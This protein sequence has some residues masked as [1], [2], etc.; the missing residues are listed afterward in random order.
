MAMFNPYL[1]AIRKQFL[2]K[3]E[4]AQKQRNPGGKRCS[5]RGCQYFESSASSPCGLRCKLQVLERED[6]VQRDRGKWNKQDTQKSPRTSTSDK[7]LPGAG[8]NSARGTRHSTKSTRVTSST[9]RR[10]GS[11]EPPAGDTPNDIDRHGI[12][13][14]LGTAAERQRKLDRLAPLLKATPLAPGTSGV[15]SSPTRRPLLSTAESEAAGVNALPKDVLF[16]VL[17]F[18]DIP[19]LIYACAPVS[20]RFRDVVLRELV[21]GVGAIR[22][23]WTA[24]EG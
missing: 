17:N 24:N 19:E 13:L 15:R 16:C 7:K 14:E 22:C 10:K 23:L 21:G 6:R 3:K 5:W 1:Q 18:F 11:R 8:T 4:A 2:E 9:A 12:N 20:K